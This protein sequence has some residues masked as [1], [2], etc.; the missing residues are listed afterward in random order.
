MLFCYGLARGIQS[1][2]PG[3]GSDQISDQISEAKA[4]EM[5]AAHPKVTPPSVGSR[6]TQNSARARV[7][8]HTDLL[9]GLDGRGPGA[10]RFRDLVSA[11]IADMGGV[12]NCSEIK[13]V[14]LRRLAAASVLVEHI[15]ARALNGGAIDIAEFCNLASTTVRISSRVG[16]TRQTRNVTPTLAEYIE[17][18]VE[19]TEGDER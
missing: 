6:V 3:V 17:A 18:G 7:S 1:A 12:Q 9:P 15:E 2:D 11:F 8:N 10:R 16:L 19:E 13:L 4:Y 5:P 14:L